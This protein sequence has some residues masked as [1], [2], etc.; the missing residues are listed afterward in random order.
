MPINP[1]TPFNYELSPLTLPLG[2]SACG[3]YDV[4]KANPGDGETAKISCQIL[5]HRHLAGD[6]LASFNYLTNQIFSFISS[7]LAKNP[8][9]R[10]TIGDKVFCQKQMGSIGDAA[11]WDFQ[12]FRLT[13]DINV[14]SIHATPGKKPQKK[15]VYHKAGLRK[16]KEILDE[17]VAADNKAQAEKK[18]DAA[19]PKKKA[20]PK[21]KVNLG[22]KKFLSALAIEGIPPVGSAPTYDKDD[23]AY[24]YTASYSRTEHERDL[25][26]KPKPVI[27]DE[28]FSNKRV[29]KRKKKS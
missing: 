16:G 9:I 6:T 29:I 12:T 2:P 1:T 22:A 27:K 18:K 20:A 5:V 7:E 4:V 11:S 24:E 13:L 23:P 28:I 8:N 25:A 10:L 26:K 19:T 14:I 3:V 17:L 21:A 15:K